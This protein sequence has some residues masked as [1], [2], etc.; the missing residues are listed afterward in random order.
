MQFTENTF[1]LCMATQAYE[2]TGAH[3]ADGTLITTP[4][5]TC[6]LMCTAYRESPC[7]DWQLTMRL[8]KHNDDKVFGSKDHKSWFKSTHPATDDFDEVERIV[9][10]DVEVFRKRMEV[11]SHS[12]RTVNTEFISVRG[13]PDDFKTAIEGNPNFHVMEVSKEEAIRDGY[14]KANDFDD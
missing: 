11:L 4:D 14:I 1:I 9:K 3:L 5:F 6:E 7:D 10:E 13:G 2:V 12:C 8:R